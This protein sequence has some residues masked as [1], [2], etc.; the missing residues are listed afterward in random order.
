MLNKDNVAFC[1]TS[2]EK[3]IEL[4]CIIHINMN[5]IKNMSRKIFY[6]IIKS[7]DVVVSGKTKSCLVGNSNVVDCQC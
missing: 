1:K 2:Q 3:F 6:K 4:I 5:V 7:L